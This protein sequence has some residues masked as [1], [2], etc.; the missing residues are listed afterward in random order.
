M[1][2]NESGR[3]H[4]LPFFLASSSFYLSWF[5]FYINF[6]LLVSLAVSD[7][8]IDWLELR[9]MHHHFSFCITSS[10]TWLFVLQHDLV[11]FAL[12]GGQL[13]AVWRTTQGDAAVSCTR[14]ESNSPEWQPAVLEQPPERD[15]L[16]T[17]P[18]TDPRQAY[19]S[20]I[21]HPGQFPLSVITKA[22]S[23]SSSEVI[24]LYWVLF[25]VTDIPTL[26]SPDRCDGDGD[27][28]SSKV[29]SIEYC[30]V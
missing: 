27:G 28:S 29:I 26:H 14:L 19:I 10:L 21:F 6:L 1:Y 15:C 9:L 24:S 11:D 3:C 18:G 2:R 5:S 25:A 20:Y 23:V 4:T 8:Y 7:A 12:S 22:L 16:V 17:D 30:L 13:W